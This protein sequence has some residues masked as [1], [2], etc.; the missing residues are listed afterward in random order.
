MSVWSLLVMIDR[1]F[2][3]SRANSLF[4]IFFKLSAPLQTISREDFPDGSVQQTIWHIGLE[5]A[6]L[7]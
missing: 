1:C 5:S 7:C 2:I 6:G 4:F 3:Q